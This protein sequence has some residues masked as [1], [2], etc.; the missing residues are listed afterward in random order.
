MVVAFTAEQ[1]GRYYLARHRSASRRGRPAFAPKLAMAYAGG[2]GYD[3]D[4]H[5][6]GATLALVVQNGGAKMYHAVPAGEWWLDAIGGL[7]QIE[8]PQDA[9]IKLVPNWGLHQMCRGAYDGDDDDMYGWFA[10][11]TFVHSQTFAFTLGPP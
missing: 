10:G 2:G 11:D 4:Y 3:F 8:D 1:L 5:A 9:D 7:P 6:A